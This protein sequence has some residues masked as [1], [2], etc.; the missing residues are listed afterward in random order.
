MTFAE[1][2]KAGGRVIRRQVAAAHRDDRV[3]LRGELLV[4]RP[5]MTDVMEDEVRATGA[6]AAL[7]PLETLFPGLKL[8]MER[9]LLSVDLRFFC[10]ETTP[11]SSDFQSEFCR[12]LED[13]VSMIEAAGFEARLN[14]RG[15][16]KR[17]DRIE[18]FCCMNKG[19]QV[20]CK[21]TGE[22]TR[23]FPFK[24]LRQSASEVLESL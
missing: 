18:S 1:T 15:E 21:P 13:A 10:Y 2:V 16:R 4:T 6:L 9:G 8:T 14:A 5:G 17:L 20:S 12:V 3:T 19:K 11:G 24:D 7:A 22:E 23:K